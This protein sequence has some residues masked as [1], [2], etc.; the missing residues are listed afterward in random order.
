L[1]YVVG[2]F[3]AVGVVLGLPL[4]FRCAAEWFGVADVDTRCDEGE[5]DEGADGAIST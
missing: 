3:F 5:V 2:D 1:A 4:P